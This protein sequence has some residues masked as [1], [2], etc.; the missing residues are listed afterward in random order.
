MSKDEEMIKVELLHAIRNGAKKTRYLVK[1]GNDYSSILLPNAKRSVSKKEF[2]E[3]MTDKDKIEGYLL[4][5]RMSL[6]K[7][8]MEYYKENILKITKKGEYQGSKYPYI[9]PKEDKGKNLIAIVDEYNDSLNAQYKK[10]EEDI[11]PYF[12]HLNSSQAFALNFFVPMM[13]ENKTD[14]FFDFDHNPINF[15]SKET[16]FEKVLTLFDKESLKEGTNLD[17]CFETTK[18][19]YITV[20]VKYSEENFGTAEADNQHN[21]KY[22]KI[23]KPALK[24]LL[25]SET[26]LSKV[27][28]FSQYQLWRNLIYTTKDCDVCFIFPEFRTDLAEEIKDAR[29]ICNS[30]CQKRIHFLFVNDFVQKMIDLTNTNLSKF[31]SEFKIKYLDLENEVEA[32]SAK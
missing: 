2:E 10:I 3:E 11:H 24:D 16:G 21:E 5:Y 6:I 12:S 30:D 22:E 27:K 15:N 13:Q 32:V 9:L 4:N 29:K 26:S 8:H 1:S 7:P 28:F 25:I 18:G 19:S 31:Y 23:Y 20:E 17:V 14:S